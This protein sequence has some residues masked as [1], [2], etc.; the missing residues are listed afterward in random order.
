[1]LEVVGRALFEGVEGA[2]QRRL[3]ISLRREGVAGVAW[4]ETARGRLVELH[5][6]LEDPR[7]GVDR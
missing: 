1:M 4:G 2:G 7:V 6:G 5:L 3:R